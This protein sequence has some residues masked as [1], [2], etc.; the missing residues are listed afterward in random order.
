MTQKL[1]AHT[2]APQV[3]APAHLVGGRK[4]HQRAALNPMRGRKQVRVTVAGSLW[5]ARHGEIVPCS[6]LPFTGTHPMT[7]PMY[8][9]SVPV[10]QQML[11]ALK[12]ILAQAS[13]HAAAKSVDRA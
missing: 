8:T 9:H 1:S 5:H 7:S 2:A 3:T 4:L 10:F 13:E 12:T 11:T 6:S